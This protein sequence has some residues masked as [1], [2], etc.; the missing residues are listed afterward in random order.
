MALSGTRGAQTGHHGLHPPLW[1]GAASACPKGPWGAQKVA[2]GGDSFPELPWEIWGAGTPPTSALGSS[3][4]EPRATRCHP[5]QPPRWEQPWPAQPAQPRFPEPPRCVR[6][7]LRLPNLRVM[8]ESGAGGA[9]PGVS[10]LAASR[11]LGCRA[12]AGSSLPA[13]RVCSCAHTC[14]G[15]GITWHTGA[16]GGAARQ[17][18][19]D[20]AEDGRLALA[21]SLPVWPRGTGGPGGSAGPMASAAHPPARRSP[22]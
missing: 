21:Q 13:S 1:A 12:H 11:T 10:V 6:K 7:L 8:C 2:M 20:L 19:R 15:A 18:L 22:G 3:R 4:R 14:A 17:L 9:G 5:P 16:P